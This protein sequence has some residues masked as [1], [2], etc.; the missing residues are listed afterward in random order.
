ML[1]LCYPY[2]D[3]EKVSNHTRLQD[4]ITTRLNIVVYS[5]LSGQVFKVFRVTDAARF[6]VR[7]S[8]G[9]ETL[10]YKLGHLGQAHKN[11]EIITTLTQQAFSQVASVT[12][13]FTERLFTLLSQFAGSVRLSRLGGKLQRSG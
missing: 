10:H 2:E 7:L 6:A 8:I 3:Q 12:H 4:V 13:L 1:S 9:I 5:Y 11:T